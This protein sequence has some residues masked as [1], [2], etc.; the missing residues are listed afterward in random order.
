MEG[1]FGRDSG[2]GGYEALPPCVLPSDVGRSFLEMLYPCRRKVSDGVSQV[3][4][5]M[6]T[7]I[8]YSVRN[9]CN[10]RFL[11]FTLVAFHNNIVRARAMMMNGM[12][13]R[14]ALLSFGLLPPLER[15]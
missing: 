10:S 14:I 15:Y 12:H 7:S 8:C 4:V 11:G 1:V 6:T 9:W 5:T 3:S 2:A 13:S